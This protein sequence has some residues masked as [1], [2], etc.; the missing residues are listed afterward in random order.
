MVQ[1]KDRLRKDLRERSQMLME[2]D[3]HG[4]QS[5]PVPPDGDGS[6]D[7]LKIAEED[8]L[9]KTA[10]AAVHAWG[11]CSLLPSLEPG[12]V[13]EPPN[14]CS[15]ATVLFCLILPSLKGRSGRPKRR[16]MW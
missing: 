13:T 1:I 3:E 15:I 16:V 7:G 14:G 9:E 10:A 4:A 8:T 5:R 6:K 12:L 11:I 2:N